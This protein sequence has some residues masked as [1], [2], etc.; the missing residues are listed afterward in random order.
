MSDT[1]NKSTNLAGNSNN[2]QSVPLAVPAPTIAHVPQS[3]SNTFGNNSLHPDF[4]PNQFTTTRYAEVPPEN[5]ALQVC[6]QYGKSVKCFGILDGIL[7]FLNAL[8]I[9]PWIF[10]IGSLFVVRW[11][12]GIGLSDS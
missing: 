9:W 1:N 2:S 5:A 4:N 6:W 10:L 11:G 3:N 8:I 12:K 7:C